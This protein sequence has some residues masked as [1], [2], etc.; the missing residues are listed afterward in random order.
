MSNDMANTE[1]TAASADEGRWQRYRRR[2]QAVALI[3][4]EAKHPAP[5]GAGSQDIEVRQ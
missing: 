1:A 3:V 4:T 5:S 2:D